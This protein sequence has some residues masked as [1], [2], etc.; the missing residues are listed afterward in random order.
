MLTISCVCFHGHGMFT[1]MI[2]SLR[3]CNDTFTPEYLWR[4][5]VVVWYL[6]YIINLVLISLKQIDKK[7]RM[8]NKCLT[9]RRFWYHVFTCVSL[10]PS[11]FANSMRSWTLKYFCRSNDFSNVCSWWSVKAV[12]A[13]RCF[14]L[15]PDD[16]D[17]LPK[18]LLI[19]PPSS[20]LPPGK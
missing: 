17:R 9:H 10:R 5:S 13:F 14:L 4:L 18:P 19:L 15:R 1:W 2:Y 7:N 20:S 6:N 8:K 12:R 3:S 16:P 11:L